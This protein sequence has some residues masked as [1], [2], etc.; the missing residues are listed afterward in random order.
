MLDAAASPLLIRLLRDRS[1]VPPAG[2]E[3]HALAL[4]RGRVLA[5]IARALAAEGL[6]AL[7][8]KGAALGLTVYPSAAARPMN[9]IDLLVRPGQSDRVVS[10]LAR[11]KNHGTASAGDVHRP[12]DRPFSGDLLGEVPLTIHCG[13]MSFTVE[14]H[15][16]L[17]KIV[18]RPIDARDLFARAAAAPGLPPLL[19]PS[20]EDHALL[21]A[22]HAAGHE[23]RHPIALLDIELLL[24]AGLDLAELTRRAR[25]WRLGTVMYVVMATLR[26]LGAASVE[27]RHVAAFDPGPLRRAALRRWYD[28]GAFPVARGPARLGLPWILRQSPLRDD[29]GAW[30]R[31]LALYAAARAADRLL[32]A[33]SSGP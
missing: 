24:R 5:Q 20:P 32:V 23:F 12:E 29:L 33:V 10:A 17:D 6:D 28:V 31:G 18:P 15:T 27:D 30:A 1:A 11:G 14:V 4:L 21:I 13:A 7:L 26:G 8:V 25:T 16:S 3:A 9:D 2:A 22:L 19:L